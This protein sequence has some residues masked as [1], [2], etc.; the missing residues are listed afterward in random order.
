VTKLTSVRRLADI[1]AIGAGNSAPQR[2]A[3]FQNGAYPFF[4]TSDVGRVH[5][6]DIF[7]SK[8]CL[9]SEG[10]KG[11]R[12]HPAGTILFP[13]SGAS[14]FLD[15]RVVMCVDGC[16]ASHLATILPDE[17]LV[18]PRFLFHFLTTVRAADLIQDSQYPS[19]R[20]SEIQ[21]IR[22]PL[23]S[24]SEQ[25]W[26][27]DI[28]DRANSAV[29]AARVSCGRAAADSREVFSSYLDSVFDSEHSEWVV[30]K[31]G[32]CIRFIDYR[33]RTPEKTESGMRLIT[34]KNV[35]MGFL[36]DQPMEFVHPST[37]AAWMT[38]G[39]P[40][41]GDVLFTTEAP[42]ANVAQL[43]TSE[44]V[45]FAQRIIIMQP[46]ETKLDSG[47]L[48]YALMSGTMQARIYAK[49]TGATA[50][51]IKASLLK[52]IDV[53]FPGDRGEQLAIVAKLDS[54]V[55]QTEQLRQIYRR[56]LEI[57]DELKQSLLHVAF[58]GQLQRAIPNEGVKRAE[59]MN[60]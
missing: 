8:D 2:Q 37:Y 58:S 55:T 36:R 3:L 49:G 44:R 10:I 56:K 48:K 46:D 30:S 12:F 47:F 60:S 13:K 28:L 33:G 27:G 53:S 42:L 16:V 23:P 5:E 15:H 51:G 14:T 7:E 21:E 24:R 54:M 20:L 4:R 52:G 6:G 59:C 41:E 22:I 38:R 32:D 25:K 31:I 40:R 35:K 39:I 26:V 50:Q 29:L 18:D 19:L 34:A 57:L 43:D 45:V 11:L 1:A 9:N 17:E